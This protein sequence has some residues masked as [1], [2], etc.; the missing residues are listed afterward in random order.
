MKIEADVDCNSAAVGTLGHINKKTVIDAI[1]SGAV[2][3]TII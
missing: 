2:T 3:G 1:E